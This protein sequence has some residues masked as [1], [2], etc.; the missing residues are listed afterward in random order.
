M[1]TRQPG[2]AFDVQVRRI[3]PAPRDRVFAAWTQ[4]EHLAKWMCRVT[5]QH[6]A[7]YL[8]HDLR[9]GGRY[10]IQ[11]AAPNGDHLLIF[12]E[13]REIRPPEKISFTWQCERTAAAGGNPVNETGETLVTVEFLERG[14]ETEV[15]LTHTGFFNAELRDRHQRGWNGCFDT[16][17]SVL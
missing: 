16:L 4:R 12:G 17:A 6:R 8:E 2:L 5:P 1:A 14:N 3:F 11:N 10:R 15:V 7:E 13:Y 9:P